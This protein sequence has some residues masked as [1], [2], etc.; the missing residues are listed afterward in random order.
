MKFSISLDVI[1]NALSGAP[2]IP[3]ATSDSSNV[4][5]EFYEGTLLEEKQVDDQYQNI[6]ISEASIIPSNFLGSL[7]APSI[8]NLDTNI[9]YTEN[10]GLGALDTDITI[11]G[12]TSSAGD[13]YEGG[14]IE[15]SLSTAQSTDVLKF[16]DDGSASTVNGQVSIVNSIIY[17]GNGTGAAILG[18]VDSTKNGLNGNALRVN[19][20]N[21]FQNGNFENND[22]SSQF[23]NWQIFDSGPIYFG[24]TKIA[25]LNTPTDTTPPK[26]GIPISDQNVPRE[27]GSY[28]G[29]VNDD[30][31]G[32]YSV[33]L[34][35]GSPNKIVAKNGY[36]IVRG[37]ALY[38]DNTV[39]LR[40]NDKVSFD[41]KASGGRDAFDVYNERISEKDHKDGGSLGGSFGAIKQIASQ[42]I[43]RKLPAELTKSW[44]NLM[45]AMYEYYIEPL[46][47]KF[48][49][50]AKERPRWSTGSAW[51]NLSKMV[52]DKQKIFRGKETASP[53]SIW[54]WNR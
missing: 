25:G 6:P 3:W 33:R 19:I 46:S 45:N 9:S 34:T 10:A 12:G 4:N 8:S 22:G 44:N 27:V 41:W 43:N 13:K 17:V 35:S 32:E 11:A 31:G 47:G 5:H 26:S 42:G 29:S 53:Q 15:F 51:L 38:S 30:G 24:T 49:V 52:R 50:Q 18:N 36:D 54:D 39:Y 16:T 7:G 48:Y 14:W 28:S 23:G 1:I 21:K 20:S 2:T 40:V 37:P